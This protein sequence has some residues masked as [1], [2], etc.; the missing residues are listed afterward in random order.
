[1]SV[2]D[3]NAVPVHR[4]LRR[5]VVL[6]KNVEPVSLGDSKLRA[7]C[8]RTVRPCVDLSGAQTHPSRCSCQIPVRL[9]ARYE[10]S[11][12]RQHELRRRTV[13]SQNWIRSPNHGLH[14]LNATEP[15]AA[16]PTAAE[17]SVTAPHRRGQAPTQRTRTHAVSAV[18]S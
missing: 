18:N 11:P 17:P 10:I 16:E 1:M 4:G 14:A 9:C 5:K 3:R 6:Q 2:A 12:V 15:K 8:F 13:K 7:N